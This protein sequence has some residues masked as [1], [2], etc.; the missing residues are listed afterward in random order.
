M[1]FIALFATV[2]LAARPVTIQGDTNFATYNHVDRY[3]DAATYPTVAIGSQPD[4]T[5]GDFDSTGACPVSCTYDGHSIHVQHYTSHSGQGAVKTGTAASPMPGTEDFV[6]GYYTNKIFHRCY[7]RAAGTNTA[8][9]A[10]TMP[11]GLAGKVTTM[12]SRNCQCQCASWVCA[13]GTAVCKF[14]SKQLADSKC[15]TSAKP[16]C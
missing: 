9:L 8:A 15:L 4:Q 12:A 10:F 7:H 11:E 16:T 13:S 5:V 14:H 1:K 3:S 2:A 6:A